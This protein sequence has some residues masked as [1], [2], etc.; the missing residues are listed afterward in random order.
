MQAT[1]RRLSVVSATSCARRRLIRDA[2]R[3]EPIATMKLHLALIS[4]G[5]LSLAVGADQQSL[6]PSGEITAE[7]PSIETAYPGD[8]YVQ[9]SVEPGNE[10]VTYEV[11]I[12]SPDLTD[13]KRI[14]S[15]WEVALVVRDQKGTELVSTRIEC[16][17]VSHIPPNKNEFRSFYFAIHK[18]LEAT[19]VVNIGRH[20][21]LRVLFTRY[22]LPM[23]SVDHPKA[24]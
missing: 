15:L 10:T 6:F 22:K 2:Q 5:C 12:Y 19:S 7:T 16:S 14:S 4:L 18:S 23:K 20:N 11:R 1:A 17:G 13:T 24:H 3:T 9:R 8:V 21:G